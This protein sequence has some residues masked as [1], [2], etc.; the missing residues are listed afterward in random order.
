MQ[1]RAGAVDVWAEHWSIELVHQQPSIGRIAFDDTDAWHPAL[2]D[3]VLAHEHDASMAEPKAGGHRRI[4]DLDDW[5]LPE[6]ELICLR[7]LKMCRALMN[8]PHVH[9]R[10]AGAL[11]V[12]EGQAVP[13]TEPDDHVAQLTYVLAGHAP[14]QFQAPKLDMPPFVPGAL[15]SVGSLFAYPGS[16]VP[17][18]PY[19]HQPEPAVLLQFGFAR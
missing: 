13:V 5:G 7:A 18:L 8:T 10:A 12:R 17:S 16:L 6:A 11:V 19:L 14:L 15:A 2:V 3:A 9:L 1:L 4:E